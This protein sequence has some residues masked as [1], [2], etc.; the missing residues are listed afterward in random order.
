MKIVK[1]KEK[2]DVCRVSDINERHIIVGILYGEPCIVTKD[3]NTNRYSFH[4][5]GERFTAGDGYSGYGFKEKSL[6]ELVNTYLG[7]RENKI[8]AFS[9]WREALQWLLDNAV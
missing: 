6:R 2:V 7:D 3:F 4:T 9:N 5:L 8:E 1:D